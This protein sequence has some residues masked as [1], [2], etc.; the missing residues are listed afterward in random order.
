M[1]EV[2]RNSDLQHFVLTRAAAARSRRKRKS[3]CASTGEQRFMQVHG[4]L[5]RDEEGRRI[6]ALV[7]LNDVT[8]LRRLETIRRDFVAN[9]SHEL[10]TPITSIKGF[11]E[12]LL[13][14]A[15]AAT[16]RCRA[17]PAHHRPAGRP[18]ECDHRGPAEP[19]RASSSRPKQRAT[20]AGARRMSAGAAQPRCKLCR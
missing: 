17:L 10:K 5:L 16:R 1:Q 7:V 14:G 19:V 4:T 12:T 18:A 11:V 15:I 20:A 2:I 3:S 6:G 13:D 9:V 8:R